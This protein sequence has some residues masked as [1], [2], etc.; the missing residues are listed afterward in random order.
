MPYIV[1]MHPVIK[2][3]LMVLQKYMPKLIGAVI[4]AGC[5]YEKEDW[6]ELKNGQNYVILRD[7]RSKRG[8]QI[9]DLLK[10]LYEMDNTV[11][12][13]TGEPQKF[14]ILLKPRKKA[15]KNAQKDREETGAGSEG[16]A[17]SEPAGNLE[18]GD[19][20]GDGLSPVRGYR[21]DDILVQNL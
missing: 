8:D 2:M 10:T 19:F 16:G 17:G 11:P 6:I 15:K 4:N 3:D 12:D 21:A 7:V 14:Y 9:G 5:E 13:E 18:S 1:N 20:D